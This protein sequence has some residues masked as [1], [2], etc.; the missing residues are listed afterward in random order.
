MCENRFGL[1]VLGMG[2][3]NA[4]R[5]ALRD[6]ALKKSKPDTSC[7]MLEVPFVPPGSGQNPFALANEIKPAA[8]RQGAHKLC[9]GFRFITSQSMVLVNHQERDT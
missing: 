1:I 3:S 2:H 4:R 6:E 7:R 5:A 8:A 9:I